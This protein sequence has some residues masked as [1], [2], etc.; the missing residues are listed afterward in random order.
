MLRP[1]DLSWRPQRETWVEMDPRC[2]RAMEEEFEKHKSRRLQQWEDEVMAEALGQVLQ[3]S[4]IKV[5]IK[6][7]IRNNQGRGTSQTMCFGLRP[8]EDLELRFSLVHYQQGDVAK[9]EG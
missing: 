5:E 9:P 7:S 6:G 4:G 1:R 3:E 2:V 8:G